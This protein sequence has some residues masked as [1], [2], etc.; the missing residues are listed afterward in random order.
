LLDSGKCVI[1]ISGVQDLRAA[2][3]QQLDDNPKAAYFLYEV[4]RMYTQRESQLLQQFLQEH[5]KLPE[6]NDELEDLF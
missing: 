6:G 3:R 1:K 5:G 4:N 2:L